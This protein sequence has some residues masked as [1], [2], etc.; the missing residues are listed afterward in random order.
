M[1]LL[2]ALEG[3]IDPVVATLDMLPA[4]FDVELAPVDILALMTAWLGL[5]RN[6]AQ[7]DGALRAL[8]HRAGE[9]SRLRGTHAGLELALELNFPGLP[10]RIDDE[11]GVRIAID[12]ELPEPKAPSFVVYCDEPIPNDLAAALLR[13]IDDFKPAHVQ[14]RLRIKG[15]RKKKDPTTDGAPPQPGDGDG[16]G[17][18]R[19][20]TDGE[21]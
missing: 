8:A 1:R 12:R 21:A 17:D 16:G 10:L 19:P 15:S 2:G 14:S 3:V 7:A 20:A 9:L 5:A 13:V 18:G 4:H 11:G 6:E